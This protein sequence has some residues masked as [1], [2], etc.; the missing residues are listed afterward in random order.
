MSVRGFEFSASD[1]R[2]CAAKR[3]LTVAP[4]DRSGTQRFPKYFNVWWAYLDRIV[5][6]R[7]WA[8]EKY[9]LRT[10]HPA[11]KPIDVEFAGALRQDLEQVAAME[12]VIKCIQTSGG[13]VLSLA[14]GQGKTCCACW[15]IGQ[16]KLKTVVLVHKDVLR[17]QWADRLAQFLPAAKVT[18]VQG[19]H[20]DTSGD[21]IIAMLQT[22]TSRTVDFPG[23]G[24]LVADECF[25]CDQKILTEEGPMNIGKIYNLWRRGQPVRVQSFNET[26]QRFELRDVTHAWEKHA[27]ELVKISYSK[28]NYRATSNHPVLTTEGWKPTGELVPG[29]LLISR[30][31]PG[32]HEQAVALAMNPDQYQVFIGSLLGD[33]H[34]QTLPSH[35]YRLKITHGPKQL[36]YIEWKAGIFGTKVRSFIGGY[37]NAQEYA[38]STRVI[39]LPKH[40]TFQSHKTHC[41]QWVLDEL[42]ARGLAVWL[43]DDGSVEQGG[44]IKI[45][46]N[47]FDE[48]SQRRMCL[49]LAEFGIDS[50]YK[51]TTKKDDR[52]FFYI[53][54][55]SHSGRKV[56][57]L[58][59]P[60]IHPSMAYKV[61]S[62]AKHMVGTY[63]WDSTF[64]SYGTLRVDSTQRETPTNTRVYDLEVQGTHTFVCS[65]L[66]GNGPVVHNCHHIAAETFSTAMR[67]LCTQYTLGL[68]ATPDR[69]D[70]LSRVVHWF[71]GPLAYASKRENMTEVTVEIARYSCDRYKLPPPMNRGGKVNHTAVITDMADDTVRTEF[72]IKY[73]KKLRE[74]P[75]RVILVLSHRR[76]HCTDIAR[77]IEGAV[78]FIGGSK[79]DAASAPVVCATFAFASEGYDDPRLNA[80]VLATPCSDVT[81]AVGRILRGTPT[82]PPVI[83]DIQ[84]DYSI[85]YAQSAKRKA[86]Y[87]QCGFRYASQLKQEYPRCTI[88]D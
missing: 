5:V 31:A 82:K 36:E 66:N 42:D 39:D 43:M 16:L 19:T 71:L 9:G 58:V 23:V 79:V 45:H 10:Q 59:A 85:A 17:L 48:D 35:R 75:D 3:E 51:T 49:R 20:I 57:D 8:L 30:Y 11:G 55:L 74:D 7:F 72:I 38:F 21:V 76:D 26:T 81:Q 64:L 63:Q 73:I 4:I 69:K 13:A 41:P 29:D 18:F 68:S 32:L 25:P 65:S 61:Y 44:Q 37:L 22:V 34:L 52:S 56:A 88:I 62:S 1:P 40:K 87:A 6:P 27:T 84:D 77:R 78:A 70:G 28:S 33:G 2:V 12:A 67:G 50:E 14:T 53:N 46:T 80:L 47:T 24:V 60:Y 54:I 83:V 86:Y 15:L